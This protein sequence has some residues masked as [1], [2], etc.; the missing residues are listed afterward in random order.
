M[1][2]LAVTPTGRR[3]SIE[4][5]LLMAG[6]QSPH[7]LA[8]LLSD[9]DLV[10]AKAE[11]AKVPPIPRPTDVNSFPPVVSDTITVAQGPLGP[12][13]VAAG[14]G[15]VSSDATSVQTDSGGSLPISFSPP[16]PHCRVLL[17]RYWKNLASYQ[18]V[19]PQ[20][21]TR[22]VSLTEGTSQTD[23]QTLSAELGVSFQG[24]SASL[25]QTLSTSIT[26]ESSTTVTESYSIDVPS[27][28][29]FIYTIWQLV[30]AILIVDAN[31]NPVTTSGQISLSIPGVGAPFVMNIPYSLPVNSLIQPGVRRAADP[32][33]F[34]T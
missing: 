26:I 27:G 33:P 22:T 11:D 20:T 2:L 1:R 29:T 12:I 21:F 23:A 34:D 13:N 28:K 30:D 19:G 24:I 17:Q 8:I 25:S 4:P 5:E 32:V 15:Y 9:K 16:V 14:N 31:G 10:A 7:G 18:I 6:G 3:V